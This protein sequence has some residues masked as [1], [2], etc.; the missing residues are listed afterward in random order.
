MSNDVYGFIAPFIKEIV[1][2]NGA[3]LETSL[4][5]TESTDTSLEGL[6]KF[7]MTLRS[8]EKNKPPTLLDLRFRAVHMK[9]P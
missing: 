9:T 7:V 8:M 5:R 2:G 4:T 3:F 1:F 6:K